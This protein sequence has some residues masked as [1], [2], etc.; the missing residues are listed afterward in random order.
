M[1]I[2]GFWPNARKRRA[3]EDGYCLQDIINEIPPDKVGYIDINSCFYSRMSNSEAGIQALAN[4]I[5][6]LFGASGNVVAVLDGKRS[7]EKRLASSLRQKRLEAA[8]RNLREVLNEEDFTSRV[9]R[10][11]WRHIEKL[12]QRTNTVT[13]ETTVTLS[14]A[15]KTLNVRVV[16]ADYEADVYIAQQHDVHF[17][18]SRDS[19]LIFHRN[20][21]VLYSPKTRSRFCTLQRVQKA[22]LLEKFELTASAFQAL[23]IVTGNDYVT[24]IPEF[25]FCSNI[26]F[27]R[28]LSKELV[29]DAGVEEFVY[30]YCDELGVARNHFEMAYKIFVMLS[31]SAE[32]QHSSPLSSVA[33]AV[34]L[35]SE[36]AEL[37]QRVHELKAEYRQAIQALRE[38]KR[39]SRQYSSLKTYYHE[40]RFRPLFQRETLRY[41]FRQVDHTNQSRA[42]PP[43]LPRERPKRIADQ[44]K[45]DD[46]DGSGYR[47]DDDGPK[48]P[49]DT[50]SKGKNKKG[51][52]RSSGKRSRDAANVKEPGEKRARTAQ[53]VELTSLKNNHAVKTLV[54]GGLYSRLKKGVGKDSLL[55]EYCS[56]MI[57][58]AVDEL[59]TLKMLA[60]L[61]VSEF[62]NR[63]LE[64]GEIENVR[65]LDE[66][67]LSST[68]GNGGRLFWGGVLSLIRNGKRRES[69]HTASVML[70]EE[71]MK[72]DLKALYTLI[73]GTFKW[74]VD[75]SG[76]VVRIDISEQLCL[77]RALESL[78]DELDKEFAQVI[79]GRIEFVAADVLEYQKSYLET[80]C[81]GEELRLAIEQVECAIEEMESVDGKVELFYELNQ[82]LPKQ[83]RWSFPSSAPTHAFC[84]FTEEALVKLLLSESKWKPYKETFGI[85][86]DEDAKQRYAAIQQE[87][88]DLARS[89]Y[90]ISATDDMSK[91]F[92]NLYKERKGHVICFLFGSNYKQKLKVLDDDREARYILSQSICTNGKELQLRAVDT[93]STRK[94]TGIPPTQRS[95][96]EAAKDTTKTKKFRFDRYEGLPYSDDTWYVGIDLGQR[97]LASACAVKGSGD[98]RVV[99]NLA[100]KAKAVRE[101]MRL[102]SSW[103]TSTKEAYDAQDSDKI[104]GWERQLERKSSQSW[105]EYF[106]AYVAAFMSLSQFYNSNSMKRRKWDVKKALRG[107]YDRAV[108][109]ILRMVDT[110]ISR[111]SENDK[112]V[113]GIGDCD[114]SYG[115]SEDHKSFKTYL[116]NKLKSL[117]YRVYGIGEYNTSQKCPRKDCH[118][119]CEFVSMR[120]KYCR[121]CHVFYHRDIMA[122]ENIA[123]ALIAKCKGEDRPAHLRPSKK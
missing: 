52:Y 29:D 75:G 54:V 108:N 32:V 97:Y 57:H 84:E 78:R 58:R 15:L 17:V 63:V 11:K 74:T 62:I 7:V 20:V 48:Q 61:L 107:E 66:I 59:N 111:K 113:F 106:R 114:F 9:S 33:T 27:L 42:V 24:N 8:M 65:V 85:P 64:S 82:I 94:G 5:Y 25:G 3:I 91:F 12:I 40:N 100:I 68:K 19:D 45:G 49:K 60:C 43:P 2:K 115:Q 22:T 112:V 37:L 109:A 93:K 44:E 53:T 116:Y 86:A 36:R 73:P 90:D 79:M 77:S 103:L 16:I 26:K 47:P 102:Y 50:E 70:F 98:S 56:K 123:S 23:A 18:I 21:P 10:A 101:P 87:F 80:H 46:G 83:Q 55:V 120:V 88:K 13:Q 118:E 67:V 121:H 31:E 4:R 104:A 69:V 72:D 119:K 51:N 41:S 89:V 117:G 81:E 28:S 14:E 34:D 6:K 30:C 71:I 35:A 122:G 99:R 92:E 95:L 39:Q 96:I 76:K 110:N 1:G 38:D 105:D